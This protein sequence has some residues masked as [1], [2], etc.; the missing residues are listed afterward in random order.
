M[1]E[2]A[3]QIGDRRHMVACRDGEE[4]RLRQL[5]AMLDQRWAVASRAAGTLGAE[6]AMLIC[7]LMLADSLDE[8]LHRPPTE[9]GLNDAALERLAGRL[10][11][12]AM[13]LEQPA[14]A[15]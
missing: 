4:D 1:A 2:V 5:G 13:A 8:A 15:S 12:I 9:G 3:L 6:R 10:E 11:A 7:A 14:S